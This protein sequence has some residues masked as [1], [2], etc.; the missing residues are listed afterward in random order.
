[1]KT[2]SLIFKFLS[3]ITG[4]AAYTNVIPLKYAAVAALVFAVASTLKDLVIKIGDW[5]DDHKLNG[6]YKPDILQ[7]VLLLA[8]PALLFTGC[9]TAFKAEKATDITVTA[10]MHA[11][12]DYV[13]ENHPPASQE[14]AVR[15][16]W[17]KY[18]AAQL[19]AISSTKLASHASPTNSL[20][21]NFAAMDE[22]AA[23][24]ALAD[25]LSVIQSFGVTIP[26]K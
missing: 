2:L 13:A 16:A 21:Q 12:N 3:V 24:D 14:T 23:A 19:T 9:I 15:S 5:M 25:L 8:L 4:F 17:E 10:A 22:K 20:A 6:S 1:M 11:W 18:N 26:A 7:V